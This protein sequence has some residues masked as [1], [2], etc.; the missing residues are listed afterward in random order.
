MFL[1]FKNSILPCG[2]LRL[3]LRH[4]GFNA[5]NTGGFR[6]NVFSDIFRSIYHFSGKN[7]ACACFYRIKPR[8]QNLH[9]TQ[10]FIPHNR[11]HE[12]KGDSKIGAFIFRYRIFAPCVPKIRITQKQGSQ[13]GDFR[14]ALGFTAA[15]IQQ[16]DKK[17][18]GF[19]KIRLNIKTAAQN[20]KRLIHQI[21]I[22]I[23]SPEL[24]QKPCKW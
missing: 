14:P 6:K 15:N 21:R 13:T 11:A 7:R 3:V 1:I 8:F 16:F 10:G 12:T 22:V 20:L 4:A 23:F 18:A 19:H 2:L 17:K 5:G 24:R 9:D